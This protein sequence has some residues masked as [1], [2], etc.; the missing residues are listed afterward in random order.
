MDESLNTTVLRGAAEATIRGSGDVSGGDKRV[1]FHGTVCS[2]EVRLY[3]PVEYFSGQSGD[4]GPRI[5]QASPRRQAGRGR[6]PEIRAP[7]IDRGNEVLRHGM[8]LAD[9]LWPVRPVDEPM[10]RC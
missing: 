10:Y 1:I 7:V 5:W 6:K 4:R 8:E 2:V 3:R 9:P